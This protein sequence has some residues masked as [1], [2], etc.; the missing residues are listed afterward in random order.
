MVKGVHDLL[1]V[2][3]RS[4]GWLP[5]PPGRKGTQSN[6]APL[7]IGQRPPILFLARPIA[8]GHLQRLG[9][10]ALTLD[11]DDVRAGEKLKNL[12][13]YLANHDMHAL[14]LVDPS[15]VEADPFLHRCESLAAGYVRHIL[16]LAESLATTLPDRRSVV[17]RV[18]QKIYPPRRSCAAG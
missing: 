1:D 9:L 17:D 16:R 15:D 2:E 4:T 8:S 12:A 11:D 6:R 5:G 18:I 14:V 10:C 3:T 7:S 13:R